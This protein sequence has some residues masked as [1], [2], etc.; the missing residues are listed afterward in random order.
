MT[1]AARISYTSSGR[2]RP[3]FSFCRR[4]IRIAPIRSEESARIMHHFAASWPRAEPSAR[5]ASVLATSRPNPR[6][7]FFS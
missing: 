7:I 3:I 1:A 5:L 2:N 4:T 6:A